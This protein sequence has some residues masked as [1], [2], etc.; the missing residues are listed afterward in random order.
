MAKNLQN[1]KKV[2]EQCYADFYFANPYSPWEGGVNENIN[3]LFRQYFP[4]KTD[5]ST[6]LDQEI[7]R[8]ERKLNHRPRK[9]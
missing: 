9:V 3:G 7:N 1:T 6:I 4:K 5:F 2:S 8:I